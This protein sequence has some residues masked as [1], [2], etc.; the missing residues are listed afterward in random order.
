MTDFIAQVHRALREWDRN[1]VTQ[2]ALGTLLSIRQDLTDLSATPHHAVGTHLDQMVTALAREQGELS[3][4]LRSHFQA[5]EPIDDIAHRMGCSESTFFRKQRKAIAMLAA[6]I[7]QQESRTIATRRMR[8]EQQLRL[9]PSDMLIGA[10][11]AINDVKAILN[12]KSRHAV[13]AVEG[14]GGI[15]KSAIAAALLRAE[16]DSPD[17]LNL[18][19]ISAYHGSA[20]PLARLHTASR[21]G[22][23]STE[24][25]EQLIVQL[26]G[27]E[28][29]PTPLTV[30]A[31]HGTLN[32][33]LSRGDYLIVI[34]NLETIEDLDELLPTI[35]QLADPT[36]F[37]LTS[38]ASL[39]EYPEIV[40]FQVPELTRADVYILI[41]E[42]GASAQHM[43]IA[44]YTDAELE[45][46]YAA[47]GGN[48]LA[49]RLIVGLM[50]STALMTVVENMGQARGQTI[51]SL[52]RYIYRHAWDLLDDVSKKV[53]LVMSIVPPEGIS[54][55]DI[56]AISDVESC[57]AQDA[58]EILVDHHLVDH[59]P[60]DA[61]TSIYSIH[62]LTRSFLMELAGRWEQDE[63]EQ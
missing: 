45:P 8:L 59:R 15:G 43:D 20:N 49:I 12:H 14:I 24:L 62:S 1:D 61:Y 44:A 25:L 57:S 3:S 10:E 11:R 47:I 7:E 36:R 32:A 29:V 22:Y 39:R 54:F 40:R 21:T 50:R 42:L 41:R 35:R 52:Y 51:G 19:W 13:V 23:S 34:D 16:M 53:L 2:P 33:I 37:L 46:L 4:L 38:R 18:G 60:V 9:P 55:E 48:P 63:Q 56:V 26:A 27:E 6:L 28:A 5:R 58:L 30:D 31:A 17:H